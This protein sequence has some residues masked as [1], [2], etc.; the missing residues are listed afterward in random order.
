MVHRMSR[1]AMPTRLWVPNPSMWW[2]LPAV[3]RARESIS[4]SS[5]PDGTPSRSASIR[6]AGGNPAPAGGSR[7]PRAGYA[8]AALAVLF[9]ACRAPSRIAPAPLAVSEISSPAA[10]G[11]GEPHLAEADGRVWLSWIEADASGTGRS[12][13]YAAW[14]GASWSD[15]GTVASNRPLMVNWADFPSLLAMRDGR[16]VAHWLETGAGNPHAYDVRISW[17]GDGGAS[18]SEPLIPHRDGTATEHGFVSLVD[19][20]PGRFGALWLDGRDFA[21]AGTDE[22]GGEMSLMFA[23]FEGGTFGPEQTLDARVCDCCQTTAAPSP[24]GVFVAYRDRSAEELR[25]I[26]YVRWTPEGWGDPAT[27]HADGWRIAACPVNGPAAAAAG[28]RIVLAWYTSAQ[29]QDR[30]KA[31]F[32]EDGGRSFGEPVTIDEGTPLGRVDAV[33]LTDGSALVAWLERGADPAAQIRARRVS[34]QGDPGPSF[35]VAETKSTRASGFPRLAPF[36][37]GALA[38]WTD[39]A[40]PPR[41]RVALLSPS[42][43]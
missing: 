11:S 7:R 35:V 24:D 22:T 38:T 30:V 8:V 17:S 23:P 1:G 29:G 41:V 5:F 36:G 27:P 15:P 39:P 33:W 25:D 13:R 32:S 10:P 2:R 16:L 34:P 12:L 19:L 31:A 4:G 14:D 37:N 18:W 26:S 40:S 6:P 9:A 28:R 42:V 43:R 21:K 20:G 3:S